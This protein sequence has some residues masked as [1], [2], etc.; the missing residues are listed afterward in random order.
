M[1][2]H[3]QDGQA[4]PLTSKTC[5]IDQKNAWLKKETPAIHKNRVIRTRRSRQVALDERFALLRLEDMVPCG[6]Y[7]QKSAK[8]LMNVHKST[9]TCRWDKLTT[10][11]EWHGWLKESSVGGLDRIIVLTETLVED[12]RLAN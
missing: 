3:P 5:S 8:Y 11:V 7:V 2:N 9:T 12:G 10:A 6:V 4:M 1:V